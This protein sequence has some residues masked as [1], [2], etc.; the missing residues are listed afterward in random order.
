MNNMATGKYLLFAIPV[1]LLLGACKQTPQQLTNEESIAFAKEI[2]SSIKKGE[3]AFL[4]NS[5]DKDAFA[6]RMHLPNTADG[7]S[8]GKGILEK[9]NLGS[10]IS[11]SLSDQDNFEFIKHY[12]KDG[13][14]HIIFRLYGHKEG[15]LNYHDYELLKTDNECKIADVYIYMSGETLTETMS[16]LFNSLFEKSKNPEQQNLTG[17]DDLKEIRNLIQRG[18][19]A[20]AKK[21]YDVLPAYLK[22]TKAVLLFDVLICS[23]L[24]NEEYNEAINRFQE[25]FP[26][27]PNMNLMMID[28]YFLQ[29]DY[30]KM[31]AAVNALDSQI[32]KDPLL[33]H[34]RYLSYNLLEDKK[35]A[36]IC[37]TRLVK[38]MPDFQKG[39][40][41]LIAV[42]L[43]SKNKTLADSLISIYQKKIK[44]DQ[45]ELSSVINYYQ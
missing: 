20:E 2:Q 10:K 31:L 24:S 45:Q 25:K 38:N 34:Y 23:N 35:N 5:F 12:V 19:Y 8:Y 21:M 14:H 15:T 32:N 9:L 27:E 37:L 33:D 3:G 40:L 1:L 6:G 16:N 29:K 26:D 7:R 44:F 17:V 22:E 4:D 36:R 11:N 28:G 41:E 42:E 39:Y 30:V 43:E 18:K 13:K